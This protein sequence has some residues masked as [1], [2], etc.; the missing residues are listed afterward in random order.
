MIWLIDFLPVSEYGKNIR[1][2][3]FG[4][5]AK[6]FTHSFSKAST[7]RTFTFAE[8]LLNDLSDNRIT[9]AVGAN[10]PLYCSTVDPNSLSV[11]EIPSDYFHRSFDGWTGNQNGIIP[12][13]SSNNGH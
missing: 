4:Y 1:I 13:N 6:A 11:E 9:K 3:T 8:E 2:N 5:D 7:G 12:T 10:E